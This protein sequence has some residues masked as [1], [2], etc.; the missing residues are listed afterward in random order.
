MGAFSEFIHQQQLKN[1]EKI[2]YKILETDMYRDIFGNWLYSTDAQ[3]R[4]LLRNFE[5]DIIWRMLKKKPAYILFEGHYIEIFFA[6]SLTTDDMCIVFNY[7]DY[8]ESMED[9][10]A[11]AAITID[12][13]GKLI[14]SYIGDVKYDYT[15]EDQTIL[16]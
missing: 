13:S 3:M 16:I 11:Q 15:K 7:T 10:D 14:D 8:D 1:E 5:L 2:Y 4:F 6:H 12:K 9:E